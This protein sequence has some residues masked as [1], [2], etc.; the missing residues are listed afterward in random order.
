MPSEIRVNKIN[1]RT[2]VGTITL[3]PTGV[4]FTG[5]T[6]VA[7]LKATTGIVT[8]LSTTGNAGVGGILRQHLELQ[9]NFG[10]NLQFLDL[11]VTYTIYHDLWC[12]NSIIKF[13]M[14]ILVNFNV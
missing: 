10:D 11:V 2:G 14:F 6:T 1:S 3:S 8:T 12:S 4:D 5:I 9:D 13:W 7:T